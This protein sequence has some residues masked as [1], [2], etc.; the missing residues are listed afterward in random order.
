MVTQVGLLSHLVAAAAYAALAV[1]LLLR[2]RQR[3]DVWLVLAA[4]VTA[5]WALT[6]VAAYDHPRAAA[7]LATVETLRTASW[8]ALLLSLLRASWSLDR[9]ARRTFG[10]AATVGFGIAV[11]L[12]L[13]LALH[14]V[15]R[16]LPW[17]EQ[18]PAVALFIA[19]RLTAAITGLLLVQNL[20]AASNAEDR[21]L[22]RLLAVA[23]GA[24]FAYDLNL[25]T[26]QFLLGA[27]SPGLYNTRGAADAL[28]VPLIAVAVW[29]TGALRLR[30]SRQVAFHSLGFGIIGGYLIVMSL[31]S[32]GL[33]LTGGSWGLL[34]QVLFLFGT[35]V[36][37]TTVLLSAR[38]RAQLR[39]RI[40][41]NFF[42]YRY[43]YRREWLRVIGTISRD[44]TQDGPIRERVIEAVCTVFDSPG[45]VMYEPDEGGRLEPAA[46]WRWR[47]LE[48]PA[49]E[50][51]APAVAFMREHKRVVA[52]DLLRDGTESD[53]PLPAFADAD[54][55]IWLLIPL[56]HADRLQG[57][58]MLERSLAPRALNWEDFDLLRLLGRQA[59]SY[60]MEARAQAAL[61]QARAFEEFN[62]RN[63]FIMHD[64]KNVVSQ[65]QLLS[66]NAEKHAAKP[67]FQADMVA[68]LQAATGK[69]SDLLA[70]MAHREDPRER[71]GTT[72]VPLAGLV[73]A[74][75]AEKRRARAGLVLTVVHEPVV[76]GDPLQLEQVFQH[77]IQN[78][79]DASQAL[80]PVVITVRQDD[81]RAVVRIADQGHGMSEAF[82][83]DEL[84]LPF[85]STK[86]GGFGIGAYEAREIV[87]QHHGSIRVTSRPGTGTVFDISLPVMADVVDGDVRMKDEAA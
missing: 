65:L 49:L 87:R 79:I 37:G 60:V 39:V 15:E 2:G 32:Y 40:A 75:V 10:V 29:R 14:V 26:L 8:I 18:S 81:G 48:P 55:S 35:A 61:D 27:I 58:L 64:I 77:L 20:F 54:R 4:S 67:A 47:R 83:R 86:P 33:R 13:G 3:A 41:K 80:A 73:S 51:D 5:L 57:A 22:A 68:T 16:G 43:D 52:F 46:R 56:V 34:L 70:M 30:V 31:L 38:F 17:V 84:Y 85:R 6:F 36:F 23:V 59:A 53:L 44:D 72:P 66:R 12:A 19:L 69:M 76:A 9:Q 1:I 21:L 42:T 82:I 63:A 50:A 62:R 25:Y 45:G 78:A 11:Q 74:V 24:L 28:I 7:W 71:G